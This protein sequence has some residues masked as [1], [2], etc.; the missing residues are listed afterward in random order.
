MKRTFVSSVLLSLCLLGWL[1]AR[2]EDAKE[3]KDEKKDAPAA[4]APAVK[5]VA[6]P[7]KRE[8]GGSG[9]KQADA[10]SKT[11]T[12]GTIA[13]TNDTYTAALDSHDVDGAKGKVGTDSGFKG[14]VSGIFERGSLLILNFDKDYKKAI[15]AV[16]RGKSY[17][18][19]PDVQALVGKEILVTGKFSLHQERPEIVLESPE[20]I[21]IAQ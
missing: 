20:Q 17:S 6:P 19:F 3:A 12:F 4:E 5:P 11:V 14:T 21:K 1:T 7:A 9:Q 18:A 8:G 16:L 15:S 13:K 10:A 2:A